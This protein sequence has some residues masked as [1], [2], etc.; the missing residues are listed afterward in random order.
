[1]NKMGE[2]INHEGTVI[3]KLELEGG[4]LRR[5]IEKDILFFSACPATSAV[6]MFFGSGN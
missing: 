6:K 3:A 5:I 1:M 2:K 4:I